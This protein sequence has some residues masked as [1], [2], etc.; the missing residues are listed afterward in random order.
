MSHA[1]AERRTRDAD[2]V[3]GFGETGE[4]FVEDVGGVAEA[5]REEQGGAVP[6]QSMY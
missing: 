2:H 3:E 5:R 6:P 4:E 1:E